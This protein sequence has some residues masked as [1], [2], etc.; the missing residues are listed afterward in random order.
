MEQLPLTH[1]LGLHD[2]QLNPPILFTQTS[3]A[4]HDWEPFMHSSTSFSHANPDQAE[5]HSQVN[6]FSVWLQVPLF[7]HG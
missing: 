6:S 3:P 1:G 5:G 7:L 2:K 4:L